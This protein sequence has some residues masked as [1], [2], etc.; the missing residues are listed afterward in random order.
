MG[1]SF[2]LAHFLMKDDTDQ[3]KEKLTEAMPYLF[4]VSINGADDGDTHNMG[5]DRIVQPLGQGSY[6]VY[7]VLEILMD[8]GYKNPV[9]LQCYNIKGKAEDFLA[10][11][12]DTWRKYIQRLNK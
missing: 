9:G 7:H 10:N 2:H 5:W 11:S 8:L 1:A 6:D 12:T 4:L 3:L